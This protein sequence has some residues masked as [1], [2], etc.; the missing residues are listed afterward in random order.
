MDI[1]KNT[2]VSLTYELR[3]D[4]AEGEIVEVVD[5][6]EPFVFL[7]G[8]GNLLPEFERQLEGLNPGDSFNFGITSDNA[9]GSFDEDAVVNLP[10]NAFMV[11]GTLDTEM[12]QPG[13]TLPMRDQDGHTIMGTIV[14]LGDDFVTMDFNHPMAG[15]DLHFSG[16][17][18]AV[19][20]ASDEEV[21][22]GHVHG[23]G[24]IHH[25]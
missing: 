15:V 2:V 24:G 1:R 21:Q 11:D 8:A 10:I 17:I 25:H 5:T 22:H 12:L 18:V 20:E 6:E 16:T 19:R 3:E 7:Y 14:E 9:Y 13:N 4:N 23:E